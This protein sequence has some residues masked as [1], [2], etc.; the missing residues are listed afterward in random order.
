MPPT[1]KGR[2]CVVT[3]QVREDLAYWVNQEA[4]TARR[5]LRLMEAVMRHP[6]DGEGKSEPLKHLNPNT[7]SRRITQEHRL[8]YHVADDRITFLEARYHYED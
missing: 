1:S 4:R 7:W 3:P 6:F 2:D 8:V 5:A